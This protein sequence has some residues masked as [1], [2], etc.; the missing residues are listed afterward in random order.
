SAGAGAAARGARGAKVNAVAATLRDMCRSVRIL[1]PGGRYTQV[2]ERS[3]LLLVTRNE[4]ALP[5]RV[6]IETNSPDDFDIGDV[7]VIEIPGRGTRQVQFP[8]KSKSSESTSVTFKLV[9]SSGVQLGGDPIR[10][11]VNSNAYGKPLFY[12]TLAAGAALILLVARR[13]WHRFRGEPD[14][15]DA[16][17]PEASAQ[18]R[19][20]AGRDY[21][22]RH[23]EYEHA[24][25]HPEPE[26]TDD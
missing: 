4:L 7:G 26:S 6:R 11:S 13:L 1:D 18:D 8:A 25:P 5:I 21:T 10:L 20:L 14:P 22:W 12:V 2:S 24:H 3:P 17:R 16:D 15:A 23:N 19:F 9:S